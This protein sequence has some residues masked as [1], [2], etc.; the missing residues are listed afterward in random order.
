MKKFFE[1][2]TIKIVKFE[3]ME[4]IASSFDADGSM[5][6]DVEDDW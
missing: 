6:T 5:A 3:M 4:T 1:E 2:P